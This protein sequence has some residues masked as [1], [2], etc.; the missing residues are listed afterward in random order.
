MIEHMTF[1]VSNLAATKAFYEKAL[2]PL[3]HAV[4]YEGRHESVGV[5]GFARDGHIDTWFIN[6]ATRQ[7][8]PTHFCWRAPNRVAVNQFHRAARGAG[9]VITAHPVCVRTTTRTITVRS[10]WTRIATTRKRP[11]ITRPKR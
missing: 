4:S 10:C 2:A 7:S 3:G 5:L 1:R 9:V 11:A 8:C 6:N